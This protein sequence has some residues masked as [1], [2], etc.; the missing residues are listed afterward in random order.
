MAELTSFEAYEADEPLFESF[1]EHYSRFVGADQSEPL[2]YGSTHRNVDSVRKFLRTSPWFRTGLMGAGSVAAT[3]VIGS[4]LT[5]QANSQLHPPEYPE[6]P[7]PDVLGDSRSQEASSP[8]AIASLT[9]T[10][11]ELMDSVEVQAARRPFRDLLAE[12]LQQRLPSPSLSSLELQV[13]IAQTNRST[14]GQANPVASAAVSSSASLPN[15]MSAL[16]QLQAAPAEMPEG[17]TATESSAPELV[18]TSAASH[19][20]V[21]GSPE[22]NEAIALKPFTPGS[23]SA[24]ERIAVERASVTPLPEFQGT[25][26]TNTLVEPVPPSSLD[27]SAFLHPEMQTRPLTQEEALKISQTGE[28]NFRI[29]H[30]SSQNYQQFWADL[31]AGEPSPA[32]AY[33]FIDPRQQIVLLPFSDREGND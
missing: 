3:L 11:P 10:P 7:Q 31:N 26:T 5:E 2:L 18:E 22:L 17:V 1:N 16:P 28:S 9:P 30:V 6:Y 32:P 15:S 33:G 8:A 24:P 25:S 21:S 27:S 12:R 19:P 23:V 14:Q 13:A 20:A 4:A 29:V